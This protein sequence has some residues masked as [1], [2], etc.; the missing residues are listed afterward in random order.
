M[1][2]SKKS[3]QKETKKQDKPGKAKKAGS[4]KSSKSSKSEKSSK[5]SKSSKSEK[6]SKSSKS[7]KSEKSKSSEIDLFDDVPAVVEAPAAPAPAVAPAKVEAAPID[8]TTHYKNGKPRPP[9]KKRS[10]FDQALLEAR[11]P[12]KRKPIPPTVEEHQAFVQQVIADM[13]LNHEK[14]SQALATQ[15]GRP[16]HRNAQLKSLC[17]QM[18]H[19][20]YR[21]WF[22]R[23]GGLDMITL[24]LQP[25]QGNPPNPS[26]S[27]QLVT[28]LTKLP[29]ERQMI[30]HQELRDVMRSTSDHFQRELNFR[31]KQ[32]AYVWLITIARAEVD[33]IGK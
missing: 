13:K 16:M 15:V 18:A 14:D 33:S 1:A 24:W 4:S 7:S 2:A 31:Y 10:L 5:S 32:E 22:V 29:M 8:L 17:E 3:I 12:K 27:Q 23:M 21:S 28:L 25:I 26:I 9:P 30:K 6:S 19:P 20:N 11:G